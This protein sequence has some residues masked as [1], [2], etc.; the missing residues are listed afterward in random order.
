MEIIRWNVKPEAVAKGQQYGEPRVT[1]SNPCP[2]GCSPKP[3]VYISD[4]E[5]GLT[6]KFEDKAELEDFKSQV[7]ILQWQ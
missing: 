5:I 2:C 4:G 6:V 1:A 7:R 3:F